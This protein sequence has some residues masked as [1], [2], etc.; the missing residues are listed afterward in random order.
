MSAS[1]SSTPGL[2]GVDLTDR[3]LF[4]HGFPHELF[5]Q[6][7]REAPIWWHPET[8]GCD[9]I[10]GGGF[11]VIS[12]HA[13]IL[14]ASRAPDLFTASDG[15]GL[16]RERDR[17]SSPML[18][19]MDGERHIRQRRL[20]SAGFTPR[21]T[22][23][24]EDQARSWAIS[25]I[26]SAL[27]QETCNFVQDVAYQ[28]PMHMIADIVGIPAEDRSYIFKLVN[29]ML[30]CTDP[31][32]DVDPAQRGALLAEIF[33]YG[34]QLSARKRERPDDDVWS[35]L[36]SV[37]APSGGDEEGRLDAFELDG[38]FVLLTAA[39]S[40]T[41]RNAIAGG[42]LALLDAPD[43]LERLK[44]D[45]G[46]RRSATEEIIRW[47]SPV[48]YFR[49]TVTRDTEL[50]GVPLAAG[51]RISMWYPSGNRD[52]AVFADPFRFDITRQGNDH[53]AFGGGGAHFC[54]GAHLARR[55]ITI[56]FEELLSRVSKLEILGE[57]VYGVQGISNPIIVSLKEL[58]VRLCA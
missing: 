22:K 55:E 29:D 14:A 15:P 11:W 16:P 17:S 36:T 40:E 20:I 41:T 23:R 25:I 57:P 31:E 49:R 34:Q 39:G 7:R 1:T 30:T 28:L 4:E 3:A 12:R 19:N 56:L 32:T 6:L 21:M 5:S 37:P 44:R 46:V 53:A 35:I 24:L 8:R 45:P 48:T 43:Q 18:T 38:F 51:D 47:T 2:E 27:E 33:Q 50:G 13:D 42:L 26:E 54:L 9:E 10:D 52:D 58:R